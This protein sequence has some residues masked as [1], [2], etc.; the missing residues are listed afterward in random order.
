MLAKNKREGSV[1]TSM[2][3]DPAILEYHEFS[4]CGRICKL[5]II[6]SGAEFESPL[7]AILAF[8][9]EIN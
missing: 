7:S 9:F 3:I 1:Y 4:V 6:N 5:R 8:S 2:Y